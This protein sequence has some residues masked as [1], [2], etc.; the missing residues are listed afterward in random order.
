M[1]DGDP[2]DPRSQRS[3][4]LAQDL[5]LEDEDEGHGT[6]PDLEVRRVRAPGQLDPP[7]VPIDVT[8]YQELPLPE[9]AYPPKESSGRQS[10][11]APP[12]P[13]PSAVRSMPQPS[14]SSTT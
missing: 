14:I 4:R 10:M 5:F 3:K 12:A 9:L 1:A 8:G 7:T 13:R 2:K 11:S 6:V